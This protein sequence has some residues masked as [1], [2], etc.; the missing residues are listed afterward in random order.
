METIVKKVIV[1]SPIRSIV[2]T[3]GQLALLLDVN[4]Q[5]KAQGYLLSYDSASEK[6]IASDGLPAVNV[7]PGTYG[8]TTQIPVF[9]VLADGRLD[10]AGTV[11]VAGVTGFG[12][13]SASGKLT[14]NTA[15]GSNFETVVTLDPYTTS[16]LDEG[17]NLYYTD[18][19]VNTKWLD[20]AGNLTTSLIPESDA[21]YDLGTPDKQ[22]RSLYVSGT[23][24]YLGNLSLS[25][26]SSTFVVKDSDG[27][28]SPISFAGNTTSD[29]AEGDNLYYTTL[30]ADSDARYAISG[31]TGITYNPLTGIID[32]TNTGVTA[33]TYGSTSQIPVITINA[34]GQIDSAGTIAVATN[35][36][37]TADTGS[38]EL[39]LLTDT[40]NFSGGSGLSSIITN[41]EV[42]FNLDSSLY[43]NNIIAS[44]NANITGNIT[45]GGNLT[46]SGSQTIINTEVLNVVD[47]MIYLNSG[48]SA[49]SPVLTPIDIGWQ[50][51]YTD[52]GGFAH[53]GMFRDHD[54]KKFKV[55][56]GYTPDAGT[57][58]DVNHASFEY[59]GFKAGTL[60]GKYLGFDS[61]VFFRISSADSA[62]SFLYDSSGF[63]LTLRKATTVDA[64]VAFYANDQFGVDVNGGVTIAAVDG[65]EY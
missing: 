2:Q 42:Q 14:I 58:I 43:L 3:E 13:D 26:S 10:S 63:I 27:N 48:E 38:K 64:G 23:T 7:V 16:T 59:A 60:E 8:S 37:I 12:F 61:D 5:D 29:L 11:T 52:S 19:R 1:G 34:Q 54:T 15:D 35:L 51:G 49:G 21:V 46:V 6:W 55:Y 56:Q 18:N 47:N 33:T 62:I 53:A 39:S 25:D 20:I 31:N 40:L 17:S 24:I 28:V 4:V 44:G 36:N 50:G 9:T 30:R 57:T 32:I 41:N 22:W 65:G 45:I